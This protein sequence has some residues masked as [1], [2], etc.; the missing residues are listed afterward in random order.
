MSRVGR[1]P[2]KIPAGVAVKVENNLVEAKGPKGMLV[3]QM[4][5]EMR[6]ACEEDMIIVSRP[7]DEK[8]HRELHG[9]TR[10]L[11]QNMIT[12]VTEGF[13]KGLELIGVGY[14]AAKQGK[15]L[16]LTVG[17]S[18]PVEIEIEEGLDIEVPAPNKVIVSGIDKEKVGALAA[19]I[20]SVRKPEPY[21]GKGIRYEGEVIKLKAGKAGVKGK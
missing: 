16:V 14:R 21:K 3:R 13:K 6:I 12:G 5:L 1:L 9:L 10:A 4:P 17:Y 19:R 7:T 11:L 18:N 8:K 20:R 2:I 15:N